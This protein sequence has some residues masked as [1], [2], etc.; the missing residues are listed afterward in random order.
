M[1]ESLR[2]LLVHDYEYPL[3]DLMVPLKRLGLKSLR[4]RSCREA[5][6]ALASLLPL[7]LAFTDTEL[8]DGGWRETVRFGIAAPSPVPV[9]VVSRV[10]DIRL[11]LETIERGA[12]EFIVPPFRDA[13]IR[14][15]VQGARLNASRRA[16][17]R[18]RAP[19]QDSRVS[20]RYLAF[21]A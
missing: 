16:S 12:A 9:I 6:S 14:Y 1:I 15:L 10:V 8:P 20:P 18:S 3:R 11:Y 5:K 21:G 13:D 19:G 4:A 17:R 2:V 7:A